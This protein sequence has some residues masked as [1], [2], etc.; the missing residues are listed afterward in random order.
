MKKLACALMLMLSFIAV[1]CD[2]N[3]Q[4]S[5]GKSGEPLEQTTAPD[6]TVTALDGSSL[7]LSSLKGKVVLLTFWAT[8][9][10]P[11]REEIPSMMRLNSTMAGKPFQML[12][13][14]IDEGGKPAVDE[15]YKSTGF[16]LPT[17]LDQ[18]NAAGT[19]YGITGVPESF[20]I[21]KE[22]IIVKKIIGPVEWDSP[23]V[24]A[25]LE[26]LLK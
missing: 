7:K 23:D 24:K 25:F 19:I 13:V 16:M 21:D 2:R 12:A 18:E 8:W 6:I 5:Q 26:G 4:K 9:C 20:I 3:D 11:C 14:S 10:P 17:Y 1:A 22:G 15:F